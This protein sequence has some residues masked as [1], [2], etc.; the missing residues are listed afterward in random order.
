MRVLV[1]G[2]SGFVGRHAVNAL[3]A[4]GVEVHA[5]ARETLPIDCPWYCVD[6]LDQAQARDIVR[7]IR[8]DSIL[9]L[10]WCV[11]HGKFWTDPAN[12][13]WVASTLT[14]ARTAIDVG[15]RHFTGVG[16]CYEYDWPADEDCEESR[17]PLSG[18][19]LYDISKSGCRSVLDGLFAI[20][21]LGFAW[22]R[23]FFLYGVSEDPR[24]L[25]AS[26]AR[27]LVRGEPARCSQGLAVRDFMA[28]QDAGAALAAV[29]LAQTQ[30]S[31]NVAS[32][33]GVKVSEIANTL[34]RLSGRP[35]LIKLGALPDRADEPMRIVADITRLRDEVGFRPRL[36]PEE[37]LQVAYDYWVEHEKRSLAS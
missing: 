25:V 36:T 32:G 30:G 3:L 11:D 4:A 23:L 19:S 5:V 17:T 37:G 26:V 2:A 18:H 35:E 33:V 22:A 24:R 20:Q 9:H 6:L 7:S 1:T 13:E 12:V 10:A 27:S 28:V 15:V 34:G 29:T 16:T 8:P 14:M 21:G 31:I